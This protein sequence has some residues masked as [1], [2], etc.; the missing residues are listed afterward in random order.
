MRGVGRARE[1]AS[2]WRSGELFR[3]AT[4]LK[5]VHGRRNQGTSIHRSRWP[6]KQN[7]AA[8]TSMVE[9]EG[10]WA[11]ISTLAGNAGRALESGCIE[12]L[13]GERLTLTGQH[14]LQL[15]G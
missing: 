9:P 4:Y 2:A 12:K 15:S 8:G 10:A 13:G 7:P 1:G 14:F 6:L 5:N 11:D 3:H